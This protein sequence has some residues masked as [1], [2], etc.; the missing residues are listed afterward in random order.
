MSHF[1]WTHLAVGAI[2]LTVAAGAAA[3]ET[4]APK[5][6]PTM[7]FPQVR[8]ANEVLKLTVYLPDAEKG[9][10]RGTRF[11]WS[12]QIARA[13]FQGHTVFG[14]FRTKYDATGHD[15]CVGPAEEFDID[16][17]QGYAE[18]EVGQTFMKIGVGLI[19][20][21]KEAKYG[22]WN[23]YRIVAPGQWKVTSGKDWV[24]FRHDLAGGDWGYAYTKR[25]ALAAGK[26]AFTIN[27]TL[28][29]TGKKPID[30]TT[31]CHNFVIIDDEPVGPAYR[32]TWPFDLQVKEG[33]GKFEVAGKT[34]AFPEVA[35]A[36]VWIAFAGG[37]GRV[38]DNAVTVENTQS[39][40][41]VRI[42]SDQPAVEWRFYAEKTAACPEPFIRIQAA[43]GEEKSWRTDYAFQAGARKESKP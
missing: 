7:E 41:G 4:A 21:V 8:I 34:L 1:R 16:R 31:Y 33:R 23:K 40:A 11:D 18:A 10:Y 22:F 28:K 29:N 35:A 6:P 12:G 24:E 27:H 38:A 19:E 9:Y 13:E 5:E 14:P 26:P 30:T 3:A 25:I 17:P 42:S 39:G 36:S 15:T 2:L 32:V 37:M 20:K 43:P